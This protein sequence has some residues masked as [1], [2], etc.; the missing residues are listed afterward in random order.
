MDRPCLLKLLGVCLCG[1]TLGLQLLP[2]LVALPD[3]LFQLAGGKIL[4]IDR[5]G[6]LFALFGGHREQL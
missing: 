5:L 4:R 1:L 3:S 6:E 2:C